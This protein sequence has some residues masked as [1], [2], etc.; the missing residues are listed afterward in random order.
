MIGGLRVNTLAYTKSQTI[1][2]QL[3]AHDYPLDMPLLFRYR[4]RAGGS[5]LLP[6]IRKYQKDLLFRAAAACQRLRLLL[7]PER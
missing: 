2:Q 6:D 5:Y 1:K 7:F 4:Y 3:Q